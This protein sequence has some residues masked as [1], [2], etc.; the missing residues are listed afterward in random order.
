MATS[1]T[2]EKRRELPSQATLDEVGEI[3]IKDKDGKEVPLKSLYTGK[4]ANER[5]LII[6]VRHFFCGSCE[7][8]IEA[9]AKD[10]PPA[11]L[12][13]VDTALT[14]IGSGEPILIEGYAKR[15][16]SPYPVYT[17]NSVQIY[18]KLG[19]V[20]TLKGSMG[21]PKYT[22]K[23]FFKN[24]ID[25]MWNSVMSGHP[26]SSGPPAQNGGELLFQNGELKWC[27]RMRNPTDHTEI[28]ELKEV[29]GIKE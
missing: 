28:D 2:E 16:G 3:N 26:L 20:S 8:Y 23:G 21:G 7:Q 17:D 22:H 9:L 4:P 27:S 12:S 14:I 18:K 6:F 1:I 24:T 19:M 15:T 13:A 29:L 5:Q 11:K 10:L 25:S